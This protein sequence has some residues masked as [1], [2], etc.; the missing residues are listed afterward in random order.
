MKINIEI[1]E[2]AIKNLIA[3]HGE[4]VENVAKYIGEVA[5]NEAIKLLKTEF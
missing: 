3:Q 2:E 1:P 4:T 5:E